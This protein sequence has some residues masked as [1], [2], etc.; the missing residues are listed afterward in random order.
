MRCDL[1]V[2]SVYSTDSGNYA[3]RRARLGES[4][5]DPERV[6]RVCKTRGM[7]FVTISDH[8]TVE[9]ALQIAHHPDAFVSVEVTTHFPGEDIP[10]HVL[11]WNLTEA[12]HRDLQEYRP[13]VFELV[14]FLRARGLAHGLAHPLYRMGKL[15]TV[16]HMEQLLVLFSVWEGRNGARSAES[17]ELARRL[18]ASLTPETILR[19]A[20]RHDLEP[21]HGGHVALTGGS[22]DHGAL[23]IATTWT[24]AA[25]SSVDEFFAAIA[26]GSCAAGGAHGS[27]TKLAHALTALLVNAYRAGGGSLPEMLAARIGRLF[28]TDAEDAAERHAEIAGAMEDLARLLGERAR[29]GGVG[30]S[31][32]PGIGGRLGAVAFAAALQA[33]YLAT[34][35]HHADSRQSLRA[36]EHGFFGIEVAEPEPRVLVFTDTFEEVNGVAGTMR[37]LAAASAAGRFCG[38][39]VTAGDDA[40]EGAVALRADW[41][42]SLP[43]YESL[44]VAFPVPTEVL[45]CVERER[46]DVVHVATPGPLGL[47]GLAIA[48][49]L[50]IP[51]VGSYHTELGP[52]A[53]HLTRDLLVAQ[54][55]EAYV[56]WFYRQCATVLAPTASVATALRARGYRDVGIWGRGVDHELFHPRRRDEQLRSRLLAGGDALLLSV[57][58]ISHEKRLDN[59]L[60]A[61]VRVARVL[62]GVRLLVVGDGPARHELERT[63]PAGVAFYGEARDEALARLYAAADVFCFASTTDT[64]GQVLLEAAASGLPVVAA[65]AGGARDLVSD[66]ENGLL[67]PP[68]DVGAFAAA[69]VE[70][71]QSPASRAVYA[72]AARSSAVGRSWEAAIAQLSASYGR[73]VGIAEPRV[74]VAA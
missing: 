64:F 57:G 49:L 23:D 11:V 2:H 37:Q 28:D 8:N 48:R 29:A 30:L 14:A 26:A 6:Y 62:P 42:A 63:A 58:R 71:L 31:S 18:A 38:A 59:L 69:L 36:I 24:E 66:G 70:L 15:L 74:S 52:Y 34:A 46:P 60:Q 39:V 68:D 65:A 9:G 27:T 53:L 61:Y 35:Q 17:N 55:T 43:S 73:V 21:A 19:L 10:L 4:Y 41:I 72:A 45:A 12:D 54:A 67:V 3:L 32:L 20:G 44:N 22:D 25:A 33:P 47:C 40:P 16:A 1:H 13:S 56:D 5:T 7:D 50:G 51:V